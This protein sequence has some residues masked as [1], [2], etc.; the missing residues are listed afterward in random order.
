MTDKT[1][2]DLPPI[3][4][5]TDFAEFIVD[6]GIQTYRILASDLALYI[7]DA[8]LPSGVVNPYAGNGAP[9][10]WLLADGSE[11]SRTTYAKLFAAIGAVYGIGN[12]STTFNL[13]DLRGRV[14]AGRDDMGGTAAN[15]LTTGGSGI[16]GIALGAAGGLQTYTPSGVIGGTQSIAHTHV[17]PS[18]RHAMSHVHGWAHHGADRDIYVVTNRNTNYVAIDTSDVK[19]MDATGIFTATGSTVAYVPINLAGT[20]ATFYTTGVLDA[21]LSAGSSAGTGSAGDDVT[22]GM[23][24]AANVNGTNFSFTGVVDSNTQPTIILNYIIKT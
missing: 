3:S 13:P 16:N 17:G 15:R 22:S 6:S 19:V 23:S 10:G 9:A 5:I 2:P 1:I 7:R 20:A 8:V 24:T 14:V 12:G 4:S 21:P 18:H 11:V